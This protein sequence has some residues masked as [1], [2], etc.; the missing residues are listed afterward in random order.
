MERVLLRAALYYDLQ[1]TYDPSSL[2]VIE[3]AAGSTPGCYRDMSK[4]QEPRVQFAALPFRLV[5]ERLEVLLIT[6]RET[7]RWIIPKGWAEKGT[8]PHT[9][10]A[11][12]AFEE[13]GVRGKVGK[14]PYGSY[15]YEKR[16]TEKRSVEC[17]VTVFLL[18]VEQEMEDWPEKGERERRW[19]SR[20]R[21]RWPSAKAAWLRCCCASG[22][23][24]PE[25]RQALT[26]IAELMLWKLH[27]SI[28]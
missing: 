10:A 15:R 12:E 7:R 20:P 23:P 13:A 2:P 25:D 19:L 18:E 16:L 5:E 28:L 3:L 4:R 27:Y 14:L 17:Q 1:P 6:S 24:P 9:M 11:R 21:P 8:K 22:F 26:R